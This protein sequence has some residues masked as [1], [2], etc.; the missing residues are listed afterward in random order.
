MEGFLQGRAGQ[1]QQAQGMLFGGAHAER[2]RLGE[3]RHPWAPT[4]L[5]GNALCIWMISADV[6][7][8]LHHVIN[9]I[10]I[11]CE[12][13]LQCSSQASGTT[14]RTACN[15]H[16]AQN[17]QQGWFAGASHPSVAVCQKG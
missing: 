6:E 8:R 15:Q 2:R 10:S 11:A 12:G 4:K 14:Q 9:S 16:S 17:Q 5:V 1:G 3:T 7:W 13:A